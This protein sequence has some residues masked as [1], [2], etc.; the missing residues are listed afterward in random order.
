MRENQ[1]DMMLAF[2]PDPRDGAVVKQLGR[3]HLHP[4]VSRS[5]VEQHG[6]P[7][8][9]NIAQ[10]KFLQSSFYETGDEVWSDWLNLVSHGRISHYCDN[11]FLYGALVKRGLGIGLLGTYTAVDHD[12]VPLDL[13]VLISIPLFG[14]A[15]RERLRSRPVRIVF[16]WLCDIFSEKNHW[17]RRDF[18]PGDLAPA[19]D[20][21]RLLLT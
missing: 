13:D 1:T 2:A 14:I 11:S 21:L 12:C 17:F 3:L 9:S 18:K 10:H 20:A 8:L 19:Y 16:D 4:T 15:L 7:T 5:Y 6:L